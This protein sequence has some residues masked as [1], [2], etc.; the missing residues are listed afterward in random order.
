MATFHV[1]TPKSD[2]REVRTQTL[3]SGWWWLHWEDETGESNTPQTE[4]RR[5]TQLTPTEED[6]PYELV[7]LY[8]VIIEHHL[9]NNRLPVSLEECS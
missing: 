9:I 3:P 2:R 1:A 4:E 5:R 7:F 6:Q 8:R